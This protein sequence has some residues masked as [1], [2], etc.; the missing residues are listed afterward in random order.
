MQMS[1]IGMPNNLCEYSANKKGTYN[2]PSYK[3]TMNSVFVNTYVCVHKYKTHVR[4]TVSSYPPWLT[5]AGTSIL[6]PRS[7]C[8]HWYL[9]DTREDQFL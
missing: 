1:H 3:C 4:A 7:V 2:F 5:T 9:F 6:S 8:S